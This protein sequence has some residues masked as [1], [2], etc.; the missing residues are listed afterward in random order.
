MQN[1]EGMKEASAFNGAWMESPS[2]NARTHTF[3]AVMKRIGDHLA[4]RR[5]RARRAWL[6]HMTEVEISRLPPEIHKD[7]GWP[8]RR[9]EL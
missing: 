7:I 5:A 2:G 8:M 3:I 1:C 9:D 4:E 6:R